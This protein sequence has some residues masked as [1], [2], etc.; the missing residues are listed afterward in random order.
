MLYPVRALAVVFVCLLVLQTGCNPPEQHLSDNPA[1]Q[2]KPIAN[3]PDNNP[4]YRN[5]RQNPEQS[6]TQAEPLVIGSFN[7]QMFGDAKMSKPNVVSVLVDITRRF[8]ILAIQELR[9][10]DQNVIKEFVDL[11]NSDGSYYAAAIG[12]RQGYPP[13]ENVR[14]QEQCVF[15]YNTRTVEMI[16]GNYAAADPSRLMYRPPFV[17]HFRAATVEPDQAFSFVLMN[18]HVRPKNPEI[19]FRVLS[20]VFAGVYNNHDE[21]D[22]ILLGD[23]NDRPID[24]QQ[25]GWMSNQVTA[26]GGDIKTNT[27]QTKSYDNL[28]F[29]SLTTSEFTGNAGV[30]NLMNVYN[31]TLADAQL[32]SDHLPVW[33]T[34]SPYENRSNAITQNPSGVVR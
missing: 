19:E 21:D 28:V 1:L 11:I 17:G 7:I 24:Y 2:G 10:K 5:V 29:N 9:N 26:L 23:L 14:Y 3:A 8:D 13:G 16:G 18:V 22:F 12:P 31:L 6:T 15:I 30:I 34:F 20:N 25:Y 27:V 32:V 4:N 33:A